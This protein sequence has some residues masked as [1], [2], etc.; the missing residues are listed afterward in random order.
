MRY[1]QQQFSGKM[2]RFT[3]IELLI[4]IS[5][6]AILAALLLPALN[7]AR[8][9]AKDISCRNNLKNYHLLMAQYANDYQSYYPQW[10]GNTYCWTRQLGELY[11]DHKYDSSNYVINGSKVF[12]CPS[13]VIDPQYSKKPR[14]YAMNAY[15]AGSDHYYSGT[16]SPAGFSAV[17]RRDIPFN[18]N[19]RMMLV[20]DFGLDGKETFFG[21]QANNSE[22]LYRWHGRRIMNRHQKKI[23]YV[24]KSGAVM[25]SFKRNDGTTGDIGLDIIWFIVDQTHYMRNNTTYSF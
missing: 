12:H 3:L 4:V 1:M 22:Y 15:V 19:S 25:Q 13:G 23:N 24:V 2:N 18:N 11:L 14:G 10:Q 5:I 7:K 9:S 21:G 6:I 16:D 8:E 17:N 20:A